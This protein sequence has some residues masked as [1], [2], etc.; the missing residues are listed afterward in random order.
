MSI[1]NAQ[2]DD[3]P[4]TGAITG[5]KEPTHE[6]TTPPGNQEVDPDK[7]ERSLEDAE[8]PGGGH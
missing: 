8:K 2:P 4:T 3:V 7:L 5:P 6:A 1:E